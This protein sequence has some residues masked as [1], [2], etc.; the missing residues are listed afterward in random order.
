MNRLPKIIAT[1]FGLG[2]APIAPGTIG[3]LGGL[4]IS[5]LLMKSD[6]QNSA[7]QLVHIFL[8]LISYF[9]GVYACKKLVSEWGHDPSR[10]VI[11]ETMGFWISILFMPLEI[12]VLVSGFVLFRFFDILKPLGIKKIDQLKS[13][14]SVMLDD[15][16]AGIYANI[17]LQI[18]LCFGQSYF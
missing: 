13:N 9:A 18:I 16:L 3:A 5:I 17:T 12:Y 10:V 2:Y 1:F 4:L 8:I 15:V 14:H 6:M 11:D 7:F